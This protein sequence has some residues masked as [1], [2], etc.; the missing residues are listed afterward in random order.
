MNIFKFYIENY[1]QIQKHRI[2]SYNSEYN[3]PSAK[4]TN[5]RHDR[6]SPTL[7]LPEK[8]QTQS[9]ISVISSSK[10]KTQLINNPQQRTTNLSSSYQHLKSYKK[11][12][13][14]QSY[15]S[16]PKKHKR[17]EN[18]KQTEFY[19]STKNNKKKIPEQN[20]LLP[21]IQTIKNYYKHNPYAEA[22][23][24]YDE[25][26][27]Y[28]DSIQSQ[29]VFLSEDCSAIIPR[30]EYDS[31]L[32][33]FNGFVTP[34]ING[35]PVENAFD[36]SYF[37]ELKDFLETKPRANLVNVHLLQPIPNPNAYAAP[38][39]TVLAAYG[40]DSKVTSIDILKRWIIIYQE[41]HSRNV[42]V[43]G[44]AT[45]GDPKYLRAM[46]LASNFF[47]TKP[48]LN[49][50]ND[51]LPFTVEIPCSWSSW[52]FFNSCQLFLYM[53]DGVHLCTKIRNRLLS[54]NVKLKM[55]VYQVS[56]QHLYLLI[57]TT[58]RIDHNLSKSDLNVRDKQNFSS[59][60]K[61]SDDKVLDLLLLNDQH[62]ATYHYL[63]LLNLLIITYTRPNVSLLTRIYYAWII[64][65]FVRFWRIWL[66]KT[67][68]KRRSL[69]NS[70]KHAEQTYFITSNA[71]LSI[72]LNAHCLIYIYLLIEQK[73]I[74]ES[75]ANYIHLLSSQ[76]CENVFRDA[77]ALSGIY[78]TRI[79]FT[80]KQF[81]QRI[82]KLN[83]LTELK[84][85]ES[86]NKYEQIIFPV[87]HKIKPVT[88]ETELD[89]I[90]EDNN[91]N[92]DNVEIIVYRAFE[93]AQQMVISLGM[94][95]DLIK[96]KVFNIEESSQ[97][98]HKLLK[99]NTLTES[100]ILI[101]D[102]RDDSDEEINFDEDGDD[103]EE[104]VHTEDDEQ[105]DSFE[106]DSVDENDFE[107]DDHAEDGDVEDCL[108]QDGEELNENVY[109][110]YSS[111]DDSQPTSSFENLKATSYSGAY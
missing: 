29:F 106:E 100:E 58:N 111:D 104:E 79:N 70:K 5:N 48:T 64:L 43:L 88:I 66:S 86:S 91:F 41:L 67:K 98:A 51:K 25:A 110:Y 101:L 37:E 71:L 76:P 109:D 95:K 2:E 47:V 99:L 44:F 108:D 24:R 72:E 6:Q 32:N 30:V 107:E 20:F 21:S 18:E 81:L 62:K 28:L 103:D 63:L 11:K 16:Q 26:K 7:T 34:I 3:A 46:R 31:T 90:D 77:R 10:P 4:T 19:P 69:A 12:N 45:D 83:A 57:K 78:S 55:G 73:L 54:Q 85:F 59:C 38:S 53:Q 27:C 93:A 87:H 74:P 82:N 105:E 15:S 9:S 61:I 94:N 92:S 84:Q 8:G 36:C 42:R 60:G 65:F 17:D 68:R 40:T 22:K 89:D 52:Y 56:V 14:D 102:D 1:S 49:I 33:C 39:A 13:L 97:T 75:T 35:K 80:M 96:Y 50:Y 23:F